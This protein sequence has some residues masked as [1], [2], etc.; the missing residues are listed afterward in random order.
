[1]FRGA[2]VARVNK[3]RS[4]HTRNL[5]TI[6]KNCKFAFGSSKSSSSSAG[7]PI[8]SAATHEYR[9]TIVWAAE[10]IGKR[11]EILTWNF[12]RTNLE[13]TESSGG[14]KDTLTVTPPLIRKKT[15]EN[16]FHSNK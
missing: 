14:W 1:M 9:E 8:S 16:P 5:S 6:I 11:I 2:S 15:T 7:E 13:L 10:L 3:T 12:I 4:L